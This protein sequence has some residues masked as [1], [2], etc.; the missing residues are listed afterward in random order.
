MITF[1]YHNSTLRKQSSF[2]LGNV[3]P[4]ISLSAWILS[5]N[6]PCGC[7]IPW[8]TASAEQSYSPKVT[9]SSLLVSKDLSI[10]DYES[11]CLSTQ[12]HITLKHHPIFRTQVEWAEVSVDTLQLNFSFCPLLLLPFPFIHIDVKSTH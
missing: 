5:R 4:K 9:S 7:Q 3:A 2:S 12:L 8:E 1:N 10:W 11:S 6:K